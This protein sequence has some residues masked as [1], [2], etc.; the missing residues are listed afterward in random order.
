MKKDNC[1]YL[2]GHGLQGYYCCAMSKYID[3]EDCKECNIYVEDV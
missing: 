2:E 1:R 3:K